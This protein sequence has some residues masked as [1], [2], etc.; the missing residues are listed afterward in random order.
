M[1]PYRLVASPGNHVAQRTVRRPTRQIKGTIVRF[2]AILLGTA[3]GASLLLSACEK[4]PKGQ[5]VAVV[6]GEEISL[7]ELNAELAGMRVP[8]SA[9][10]NKLRREILD[11]LVDRKLIVQKAREQGIDKTPEYISQ[12]RRLDENLLV[13]M[14]GQKVAQTVP[15][16][17][18]RDVSQYIADNPTLFS[19][20][21][22][23]LLDQIQF[24]APKDLKRLMDL[25]DA[26]T[27][28][29]MVV[30]LQ[31]LGVGFTRGKG[32][33][34][35]G[36]LDPELMKKINEL[37][38]GEPFVL[39]SNG[40]FVASVIVGRETI[41]VPPQVEKQTATELVRR[42]ALVQES[43]AQIT[44]A[45]QAADI[46]YQPGFEPL[47][48]KAAPA[49]PAPAAAKP[50]PPAPPAPVYVPAANGAA[51]AQ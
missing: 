1:V 39:P 43:R 41:G 6:N 34:D 14:L 46:K 3:I 21:Q 44:R 23:L 19:Q 32:V 48:K 37:P 26:H 10:R 29:A 18:D 15:I 20:R 50:A 5:V 7:Q 9:D 38:P 27:L 51:P 28:D 24:E 36:R 45:R 17:D 13:S 33:I 31:K 4:A 35:T 12:Q 40:Q 22:R 47:P 8:D 11:R 49:A 42:K 25:R 16:P 30:G 2:K